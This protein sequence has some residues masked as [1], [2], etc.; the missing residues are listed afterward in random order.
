MEGNQLRDRNISPLAFQPL[1][2]LLYL[3][4]D[5]NRLRTIP[6]GLLASLQVSWSS[7]DGEATLL[8][9]KQPCLGFC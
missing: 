2:S 3:R 5:W 4:L 6:R 7:Q 8:T 9:V 1:C